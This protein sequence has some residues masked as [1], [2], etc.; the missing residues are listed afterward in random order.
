MQPRIH[1]S[2]TPRRAGV[3]AFGFGG[4]NAHV[5]LEEYTGPHAAAPLQYDWD[6][7][8]FVLTGETRA[9]LLAEARR[10]Q[11]FLASA[12]KDLALRNLAWTLNCTR[13]LKP[14][15]LSVVAG[16]REDLAAKLR[17]AIERLSDQR[18]RRIRE[19]DGIY[20]F[21]Q[22]AGAAGKLAF[23]FPSDLDPAHSE[24]PKVHQGLDSPEPRAFLLV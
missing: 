5:V 2:Q 11:D 18:T 10:L 15:R 22:P 23:V 4:I 12:P 16:S 20:F 17:R 21:S 19:V 6:S 14:V 3:N 7:E 24:T 1:G 9:D 8:L 13:E